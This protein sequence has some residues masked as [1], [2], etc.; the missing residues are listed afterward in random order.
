MN[1]AAALYRT[2]MTEVLRRFHAIDRILGAKKPRTTEAQFDDEL[3][4]LQIRKIVELVTFGGIA[5]DEERYAALRAETTANQ[6]YREDQ[7]VNKILPKLASITE[8]FLPM[9]IAD[10]KR[11]QDGTFH[12]DHG[13]EEETLERFVEIFDRAGYYLHVHNPFSPI[14]KAEFD[15]AVKKSREKLIADLTYLKAVLWQ[16]AKVGLKFDKAVD[17]P[18]ELAEAEAIWIVYLGKPKPDQVRM[19][20]A[21][22][23]DQPEPNGDQASQIT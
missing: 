18:K 3:M 21:Q 15:E 13:G 12:Y 2:Q 22:G 14:K 19:M 23:I 20:I 5:A 8:H 1:A 4:W 7:K 10:P 9:P 16:H 6:D 11:I 17:K